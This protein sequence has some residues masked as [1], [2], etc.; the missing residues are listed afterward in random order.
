M[1]WAQVALLPTIIS[2]HILHSFSILPFGLLRL[3]HGSLSLP[4]N[5]SFDAWAVHYDSRLRSFQGLQ[6]R[7]RG[8]L[9]LNFLPLGSEQPPFQVYWPVDM[10]SLS[11]FPPCRRLYE[12]TTDSPFCAEVPRG[13]DDP[14]TRSRATTVAPVWRFPSFSKLLPS[15]PDQLTIDHPWFTA[16]VLAQRLH[17][18]QD[19]SPILQP[20]GVP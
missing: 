6:Q 15:V 3:P 2:S 5:P 12:R 19:F 16:K 7:H 4:G 9:V 17:L 8:F 13:E 10:C 18:S 11:T 14:T 1:C 20:V